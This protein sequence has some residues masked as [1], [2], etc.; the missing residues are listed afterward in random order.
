M[1]EE[2]M[3]D[4]LIINQSSKCPVPS[5]NEYVPDELHD[6]VKDFE[7]EGFVRGTNLLGI[8]CSKCGL[9]FKYK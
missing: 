4:M 6:F 3:N 1:N 9:A 2:L 5:R 7:E 8:H